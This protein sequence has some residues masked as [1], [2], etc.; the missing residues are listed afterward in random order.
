MVLEK[1][2]GNAKASAL[3]KRNARLYRAAMLVLICVFAASACALFRYVQDGRR[4]ETFNDRMRAVLERGLQAS[5]AEDREKNLALL[6]VELKRLNPDVTGWLLTEDG[7]ISQ[8][9]VQGADNEHYLTTGADGKRNSR[10]AVFM[11]YRNGP[12]TDFNTVLYGHNMRDG[13]MFGSLADMGADLAREKG[14]LLTLGEGG[15]LC[16]EVFSA[17]TVDVETE[18]SPYEIVYDGSRADMPS[19]LSELWKEFDSESRILT[20]STCVRRV[21]D[22]YR[23][24]YVIQ[25]RLTDAPDGAFPAD[26]V[27]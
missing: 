27:L 19:E 25:A 10:G 16:W 4:S 1:E 14:R 26:I 13:S 20:L 8:P 12:F 6:F 21:N 23:Y 17:R 18:K 2:A 15:L 9:I 22:K 24:R 7:A 11:D 5:D 3:S